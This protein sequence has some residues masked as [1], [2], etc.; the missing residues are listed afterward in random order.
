MR[1]RWLASAL[2]FVALVAATAL[3]SCS[4]SGQGDGTK[5][6][7]FE[8]RAAGV[9]LTVPNGW[10]ATMRHFTPLLDPYERATLTS[11][12]VEG[13]A[14]SRGCSPGGL[15]E[16]MPRSGVSASLLEYLDA[17][18][19]RHVKPRPRHFHL[20]KEAFPGFECF[21]PPRGRAD[22][23]AF[24]FGASGRAFLLLVAVGKKATPE[25]RQVAA[26]AL[27]RIRIEPCD[28]PLPSEVKAAC[29]RPLPH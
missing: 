28:G 17:A 16:Q 25:T 15:L 10:H 5:G 7:V 20:G 19:R 13:A 8:N 22:A 12:P 9:A 29:R 6:D 21:W 26:A 2:F 18:Q 14:R 24:N 4:S 1:A 3:A 23:Y 27:D 11:Y